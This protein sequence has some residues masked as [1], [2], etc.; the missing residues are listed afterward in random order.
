MNH[1][2]CHFVEEYDDGPQGGSETWSLV[3]PCTK[4]KAWTVS[5]QDFGPQSHVLRAEQHAERLPES[6]E[7]MHRT[8]IFV[9]RLF[10]QVGLTDDPVGWAADN[11]TA[12]LALASG[13]ID[14]WSGNEWAYSFEPNVWLLDDSRRRV[15]DFLC[16]D[17]STGQ[18][19]FCSYQDVEF[20]LGC[21]R[22]ES[23]ALVRP[24]DEQTWGRRAC[25]NV[26]AVTG[27]IR[28]V[29]VLCE[30]H[31]RGMENRA[32][33]V[34]AAIHAWSGASSLVLSG[35]QYLRTGG[36]VTFSRFDTDVTLVPDAR[37]ADSLEWWPPRPQWV[38]SGDE[39]T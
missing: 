31:V 29:E 25:E 8:R 33:P 20:G 21:Q 6:A 11:V 19:T 9:N 28:A 18:T 22:G 37:D 2:E 26:P 38:R 15:Y 16:A 12:M 27:R 14:A 39:R 5:R 10:E 30:S 35:D 7:L 36:Q 32:L 23:P 17:G 3:D 13:S 34:E 24:E 1:H 4:T